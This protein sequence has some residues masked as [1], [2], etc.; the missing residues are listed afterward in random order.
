MSLLEDLA[1][2][3]KA[4]AIAVKGHIPGEADGQAWGDTEIIAIGLQQS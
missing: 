2:C 1:K 4:Q 3:G